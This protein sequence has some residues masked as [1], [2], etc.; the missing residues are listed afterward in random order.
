MVEFHAHVH[1][2]HEKSLTLNVVGG[3]APVDSAVGAPSA[4]GYPRLR[5]RL[6]LTGGHPARWL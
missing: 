5:L 4:K 6:M 3:V 2:G 1:R